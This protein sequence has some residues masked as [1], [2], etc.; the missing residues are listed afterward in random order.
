MVPGR[1]WP[2]LL[3]SVRR[4]YSPAMGL[5]RVYRALV[6]LNSRTLLVVDHV[7]KIPDSLLTSMSTLFHNFNI[8]FKY[9]PFR[10]ATTGP[11][12]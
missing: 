1:W 8:H 2:S 9:V 5:R 7:E 3:L 12:V 4:A 6:L 10:S 11:D